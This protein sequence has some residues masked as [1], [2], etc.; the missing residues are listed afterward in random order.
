VL[1]LENVL[2]FFCSSKSD[3]QLYSADAR[4]RVTTLMY[5][6]LDNPK[7]FSKHVDRATA[8]FSSIALFGQ[9]AKSVDDFWTS[10][11]RLSEAI[12]DILIMICSALMKLWRRYDHN[13]LVIPRN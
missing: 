10:V 6:L 5:N 12:L 8:S 1:S 9:R 11:S 7:D 3:L 2:L 4:I 13:L